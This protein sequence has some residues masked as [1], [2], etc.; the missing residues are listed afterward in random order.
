MASTLRNAI[1]LFVSI[2]LYDV[3]LPF[4]LVFTLMYA[5]L[6]KTRV[7]GTEKFWKNSSES[8][9]IPKKNLNAMVAFVTGLFVVLSSQLVGIINQVLAQTVLLI[10]LSFLVML[11]IGSFMKQE[12]DGI[13]F[14]KDHNPVLFYGLVTVSVT[15]I[16]FIF[17]NAIT[18]ADGRSWLSVVFDGVRGSL[19]GASSELWSVLILLLLII[20]GIAFIVGNGS[21]P[22]KDD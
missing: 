14:S 21:K 11:V 2:G 1:D 5:F 18:T 3:I 4:L 10:V 7:L 9:E 6:D 15:A 8:V 12:D 16:V 19:T 13:Y 22:P 17:L 20:G